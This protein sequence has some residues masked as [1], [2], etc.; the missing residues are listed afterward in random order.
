MIGWFGALTV[1]LALIGTLAAAWGPTSAAGRVDQT[2]QAGNL[3]D[4]AKGAVTTAAL[5]KQ[6]AELTGLEPRAVV[7]ALRGGQSLAQI[8]AANGSSGQAVVDGVVAKARK[9]L[10]RAV[11]NGRMTQAEADAKL[12]E[13]TTKAGELVNDTA[14]GEKIDKGRDKLV[15]AALVPATADITG[16]EAREIRQRLV[17]GESLATI[18]SSA[19]KTTDEVLDKAVEQFRAA[20][21][22]ALK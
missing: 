2:G 19:G 10:D 7:E 11:A 5:V 16:L 1:G 6:S 13:L 17:S 18:I 3:R 22:E 12:A 20:A 14:L 8:A 21:A 4:R 9:L 15:T